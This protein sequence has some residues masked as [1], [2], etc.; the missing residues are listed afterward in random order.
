[1]RRLVARGGAHDFAE[2]CYD[3]DTGKVFDALDT[4]KLGGA[5]EKDLEGKLKP[6]AEEAKRKLVDKGGVKEIKTVRSV[7]TESGN[8]ALV[9]LKTVFGDGSS[10]EQKFYLNKNS[11]GDWKVEIGMA[12]F[13]F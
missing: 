2:A 12:A 4:A 8:H 3:G 9:T 13:G 1:M 5:T 11:D 10:E 7:L 6:A